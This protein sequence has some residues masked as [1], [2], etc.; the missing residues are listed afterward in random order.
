MSSVPIPSTRAVALETLQMSGIVTPEEIV[1]AHRR[2]DEKLEQ[3]SGHDLPEPVRERLIAKRKALCD[4]RDLLLRTSEGDAPPVQDRHVTATSVD[5][6]GTRLSDRYD[7]LELIGRGAMGCVYRAFDRLKQCDV[8]IKVISPE[9][10]QQRGVKERFVAEAKL[11]CSLS[12]PNVIR[13]HDVNIDGDRHYLTMELLHGKTLREEMDQQRSTRVPWSI[14]RCLS[15]AEDL[16]GALAFVHRHLVHRDIKPENI[17]VCTDGTPKIMD[18]GLACPEHTSPKSRPS[19]SVSSAYYLAPEYLRGVALSIQSDQYSLAVVLYELLCGRIPGGVIKDLHKVRTDVPVGVSKAIMQA[20]SDSPQERYDTTEE[21]LERL[22]KGQSA[23]A[24][25]PLRV[26]LAGAAAL[27]GIALIAGAYHLVPPS[28][29]RHLVRWSTPADRE[30]ALAGETSVRQWL[31]EL[32]GALKQHEAQRTELKEKID[33][34]E[35]AVAEG[36]TQGGA[37]P[38]PVLLETLRHRLEDVQT[39]EELL[40]S[41]LYPTQLRTQWTAEQAVAD[42]DLKEGHFASAA[43]RYQHLQSELQPRAAELPHLPELMVN[44]KT[45][46]AA[47]AQ[48]QEQGRSAPG[49]LSSAQAD[50]Y[51]TEANDALQAARYTTALTDYRQAETAYQALSTQAQL[52][53]AHLALARTR[54]AAADQ[55]AARARYIKEERERQ[56]RLAEYFRPGRQFRDPLRSG[57]QGPL[58]VIPAQRTDP[59]AASG[60]DAISAEA[61][62]AQEFQQFVAATGYQPTIRQIASLYR[63]GEGALDPDAVTPADA[64]AYLEWLNRESGKTYRLAKVRRIS[65]LGIVFRTERHLSAT[66]LPG[67]AT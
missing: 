46:K 40:S 36:R 15:M 55:A 9:I 59:S 37:R 17:W 56:A 6:V 61:V 28:S 16:T 44:W 38:A 34:I 54:A 14:E 2:L 20:L 67:G 52:E 35:E 57:G 41:G 66:D 11:A 29:I 58:M 4:A 10:L 22:R 24:G 7:V 19:Q 25:R 51:W 62:S 21:F 13:V 42:T 32:D 49:T 64:N 5:L 63:A 27:L 26:A 3:R 65:D 31:G 18:F 47:R 48:W 60:V 50:Q 23:S 39:E 1:G 43:D 53:A 30:N 12:H 8:A 45:A 33:K